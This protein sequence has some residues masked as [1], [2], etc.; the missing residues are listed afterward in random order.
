M[1]QALCSICGYK[2][3]LPPTILTSQFFFHELVRAYREELQTT[4]VGTDP[5]S[6]TLSLRWLAQ[7]IHKSCNIPFEAKGD[8]Q[9][10]I[11][12]HIAERIAEEV[13]AVN[14]YTSAWRGQATVPGEATKNVTSETQ[15]AVEERVFPWPE[16]K[17]EPTKEHEDGRFSKAFPIEF[18]TGQGDLYQPRLRNDFQVLE[19]VKH[20]LRYATGHFLSSIR[21]QRVVWAMF[22]TALRDAARQKRF[23]GSHK[24]T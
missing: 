18:P 22:N 8:T 13:A 19:W 11:I 4:D 14:A 10:E 20:L 6:R 1:W 16:I 21:G 3:F 2:N 5:E 7:F 24:H 23:T 9:D 12:T 17:A 15:A